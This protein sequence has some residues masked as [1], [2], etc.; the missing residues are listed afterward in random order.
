VDSLEKTVSDLQ[1]SLQAVQSTMQWLQGPTGAN[2]IVAQRL[3]RV[4]FAF[5]GDVSK[6]FEGDKVGFTS[7][8]RDI[9]GRCV[10]TMHGWKSEL[11]GQDG[12]VLQEFRRR[13]IRFDYLSTAGVDDA[14]VQDVNRNLAERLSLGVQH[15][16]NS[17]GINVETMVLFTVLDIVREFNVSLGP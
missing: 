7:F 14:V 4:G 17:G 16:K 2:S 15:F 6:A 10:R 11:L 3:P 13:G 1:Q 5:R 8:L 9:I 12:L